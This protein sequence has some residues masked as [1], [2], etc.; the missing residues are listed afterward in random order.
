MKKKQPTIIQ[1][2][3]VTNAK[4]DFSKIQKNVL[5][6][7]IGAIQY[8][9]D[10][11]NFGFQE[12]RVTLKTNQ[13]DK[14]RNYNEIYEAGES[15]MEKKIR[16][17][18]ID[19]EHGKQAKVITRLIS[20]IKHIENS[21]IIE[22]TI[23]S[24]TIPFLTHIGNGFTIFEQTVA[25]SLPSTYSQRIYELCCQWKG[26]GG[27][28]M[29]LDEF[30]EVLNIPFKYTNG[31]IK[32]RVLKKAK[33]DLKE[34]I[35]FDYSMSKVNSR[36][37]NYVKIKIHSTNINTSSPTQNKDLYSRIFNLLAIPFPPIDYQGYQMQISNDV[38][39][40]NEL[41]SFLK[42]LERLNKEF[43]QEKYTPT[44]YRRIVLK[45]LKED[46]DIII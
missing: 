40:K 13:L 19:P 20:S 32:E 31:H 45:S 33:N 9:M 37:Y 24:M 22:I 44:H 21:E 43:E 5:Y 27:F 10:K 1:P 29:S 41:S 25:I 2:N 16:Y 15:L 38:A 4:Y 12:E 3:M 11:D 26:K 7:I 17:T 14:N 46:Y 8:R 39:E 42:K 30:R 23:P 18:Y 28:Q 6:H 34:Y 36:A 35:D